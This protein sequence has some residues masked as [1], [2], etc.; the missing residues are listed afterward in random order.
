MT[1]A[2]GFPVHVPAAAARGGEYTQGKE[3]H[4]KTA[5]A[6]MEENAAKSLH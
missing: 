2:T 4:V 6:N 1:L 3:N 5:K